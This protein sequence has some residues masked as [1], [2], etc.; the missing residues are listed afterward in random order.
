MMEVSFDETHCTHDDGAALGSRTDRRCVV[1]AFGSIQRLRSY[2]RLSPFTQPIKNKNANDDLCLQS[3]PQ[4]ALSGSHRPPLPKW[5]RHLGMDRVSL[6]ACR[7]SNESIDQLEI[8]P[9]RN[10]GSWI[11][12]AAVSINR[13]TGGCRPPPQFQ[14]GCI[15]R[16]RSSLDPDSGNARTTAHTTTTAHGRTERENGRLVGRLT[17]VGRAAYLIVDSIPPGAPQFLNFS[18]DPRFTPDTPS[19]VRTGHHAP[20][21]LCA[22]GCG[23]ARGACSA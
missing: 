4:L 10:N 18:T 7:S 15:Q 16:H 2:D 12:S 13:L 1:K 19:R 22:R 6:P 14:Q 21:R 23:N 8:T 20:I 5:P 17:Q 9:I 3:F 11:E